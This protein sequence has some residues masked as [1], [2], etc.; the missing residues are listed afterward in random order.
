MHSLPKR[1]I[2]AVLLFSVFCLIPARAQAEVPY[3]TFTKDN[4]GRTIYMQPAY[5]PSRVIARD[6]FVEDKNGNRVYSP[7]KGP[8]DL[9][10][11]ERDEIYVADT[12]N[13]RVVHFDAE[14]N[15]VRV[16]TVPDSPL[17]QPQ[18]L[19]V[20]DNGDIYIADTGNK[21]ILR[22]DKEGNLLKEFKRPDSIFLGED[23]LFEPKNM[24]VDQRGFIYVVSKGSYQGI[25]L[26]D[27]EGNFY[28]FYGTNISEA[29]L[30]D[31]I[32]SMF[33][34]K[35]QL[36][37]QVRIL[38]AAIL[39]IDIDREGFIYTAS[40]SSVE[41]IKKLNF[42]GENLWKNLTFGEKVRESEKSSIADITIDK[43]GNVTAIDKANNAV[44]Q[45]DTN[46]KLL[47][48]WASEGRAGL[49]QIG[50]TQSP[51]AVDVNSENELFIL[52][53]SLNLI[54]VFKPTEF[55]A[56]V[57]EA[58][59]LSQE[60]RYEESESRWK[61]VVKLNAMYAPAYEGLAHVAF[62]KGNYKEAMRL[63]MLAGN[64]NG[65]SDAFW[66]LR[67]QWFQKY[68]SVIAN[69]LL[70]FALLSFMIG[71]IAKAIHIRN[72]RQVAVARDTQGGYVLFKQ[73]KHAFYI[74]KHPIDGFSDL[75]YRNM[76][77]YTSA[78]V[79]LG[80]VFLSLLAK[81]YF[82]SFTFNPIP[83]ADR[84]SGSMILV[85]ATV[86]FSY[87]VSNFLIGNISK[88]EARFKDVFVGS[89]YAL[90]PIVLLGFPLALLSN[91]MTLSEASIYNFFDSMIV[92]WCALLFF[93]KIQ[94]L[95]NYGVGG[96]IANIVLTAFTMI[97]L[98]TL[99]FIIFGM[100]SEVGKFVYAIYQEV[101]M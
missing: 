12:A 93:W 67:L 61:H 101:S 3:A 45:Y 80:L 31:K 91:V 60:G 90:F 47:F 54:Q 59:T 39:N 89:C 55:G 29:K 7:L 6:I 58:Y 94:S 19:F 27:P 96:T 17:K 82:T 98:W 52:D 74:L 64:R 57:H 63:Y 75:R 78:F 28:S 92:F 100:A 79:L 14:G 83:A 95:Q 73:L 23:F 53:E 37:R 40:G 51:V 71:K 84:E 41:Q 34:T 36:R 77:S 99:I 38:P 85:F 2:V 69:G 32:R 48:Y 50:L 18:G 65:Y 87:V 49:P 13:D 24:V 1:R 15:L 25:V 46:G 33:Y 22:L 97:V 72:V 26:L 88:G 30:I 42:R 9:F 76:G 11:D 16:I 68:F 62:F 44:L 4:H 35:E 43:N 10:I 21:R 86:W 20:A 8:Q 81:T 5:A 66:Q 56:A 70:L